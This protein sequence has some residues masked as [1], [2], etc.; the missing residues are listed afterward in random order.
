M[1]NYHCYVSFFIIYSG[2]VASYCTRGSLDLSY[3]TVIAVRVKINGKI[4]SWWLLPHDTQINCLCPNTLQIYGN[5]VLDTSPL[6]IIV[7]NRMLR[8]KTN[9]PL[10]ILFF[11]PCEGTNWIESAG[12]SLS[13]VCYCCFLP[14]RRRR[15]LPVGAGACSQCA[16]APFPSLPTGEA[17]VLEAGSSEDAAWAQQLLACCSVF[18]GRCWIGLETKGLLDWVGKE[19]Q[20]SSSAAIAC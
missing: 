2:L 13:C 3:A 11:F 19:Y 1:E 9:V 14:A 12:L 17:G 16:A 7:F 20:T 18:V 10:P 6:I 8:E 5:L 15:H 4:S